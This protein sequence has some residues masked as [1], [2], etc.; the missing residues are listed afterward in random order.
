MIISYTI[1]ELSLKNIEKYPWIQANF[2]IGKIGNT[3][4]RDIIRLLE[5]THY[6]NITQCLNIIDKYGERSDEICENILNCNDSISFGRYLAEL[7]LFA[8]LVDNLDDN[9]NAIR[10]IEGQKTPDISVK[11]NGLEFLIEIYTPMDFFG[12]QTFSK[13]VIQTLKNLNIDHGFE[14]ETK[15]ESDNFFYAFDFPDFRSVYKW[16]ENYEAEMLQFLETAKEGDSFDKE[17]F[18]E[19]I[20][21]TTRINEFNKDKHNRLVVLNESTR[22]NDTKLYFEIDDPKYFAETQWGVKIKDKISR[23]QAGDKR[24]SILRIIAINFSHSDTSNISF[25]NDKKYYD[26]LVNDINFL[27]S[28][29]K[30]YPPYDLVLPCK[31]G[32][33]C[34]FIKPINLSDFE[35]S[36]IEEMVSTI[37]LSKP[38]AKI[39]QASKSEVDQ[40]FKLMLKLDDED[41]H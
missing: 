32:F 36:K 15:I 8:Y 24:E 13:L 37:Y 17:L 20:T 11:N 14:I 16:I 10:R 2:K 9:V 19:S 4:D 41:S 39:H 35:D 40:I 21:F 27:V 7:F 5:N 25:L 34:D 31:L 30:P 22:S 3:D 18:S 38:L 33:D 29:I 6:P 28:D 1:T 12:Y 23:K 26:N